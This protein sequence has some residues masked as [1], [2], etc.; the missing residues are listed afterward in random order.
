MKLE[1]SKLA[2]NLTT[3]LLTSQPHILPNINRLIPIQ[4]SD[5]LIHFMDI[6]IRNQSYSRF[7]IQSSVR[8][9]FFSLGILIF[10]G[11]VWSF[12]EIGVSVEEEG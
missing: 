9:G 7:L 1:V 8:C 4:S 2:S 11:F 6:I 3:F 10:A 12:E 5:L